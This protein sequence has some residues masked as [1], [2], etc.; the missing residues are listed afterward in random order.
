MLPGKRQVEGVAGD[1]EQKDP[2]RACRDESERE[3]PRGQ[4][5]EVLR[6]PFPGGESGGHR[7]MDRGG[8]RMVSELC[9]KTASFFEKKKRMRFVKNRGGKGELGALFKFEGFRLLPRNGG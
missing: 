5:Q 9:P 8:Y 1:T 2:V 4:A 6:R 7:P 3:W